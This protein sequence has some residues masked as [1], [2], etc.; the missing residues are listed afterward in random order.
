MAV[1]DLLIRRFVRGVLIHFSKSSFQ[2]RVNH[3]ILAGNLVKFII[4]YRKS[5]WREEGL[6]GEVVSSGG[7]REKEVSFFE[8]TSH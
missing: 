2:G 5:Y 3:D 8:Q 6:S 7:T 4:T 1:D